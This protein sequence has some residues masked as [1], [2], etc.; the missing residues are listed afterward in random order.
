MESLLI[1]NREK[2][3]SRGNYKLSDEIRDKLDAMHTFVF[4]TKEGQ[5]IYFE[6]SGTREALIKKINNEKRAEK[7]FDAWLYSINKNK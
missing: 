2:A 5:E 7:E 3:R 6:V 1:H 4:D